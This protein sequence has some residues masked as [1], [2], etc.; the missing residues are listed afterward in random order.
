MSRQFP[1]RGSR[2]VSR[3]FALPV[4]A[5][6]ALIFGNAP[7]QSAGVTT[8]WYIG[9]LAYSQI[10]EKHPDLGRL[11]LSETVWYRR[12]TTFPDAAQTSLKD[13]KRKKESDGLSHNQV[14]DHGGFFTDY[15][16]AFEKKCG[17]GIE[18]LSAKETHCRRALAF[19]FGMVNHAIADG[20][21]HKTFIGHTTGR[22]CKLENKWGGHEYRHG[23]ADRDIDICLSSRLNG[24][25]GDIEATVKFSKAEFKRKSVALI[26]PAGEFLSG[27]DCYKCPNDAP[28]HF[29]LF[30]ADDKRVCQKRVTAPCSRI[31][32]PVLETAAAVLS[33]GASMKQALG[34][35]IA[36]DADKATR[37]FVSGLLQTAYGKEMSGKEIGGIDK[38]MGKFYTTA[39]KEPLAVLSHLGGAKS[40]TRHVEQCDWAFE[41]VMSHKAAGGIPD[42]AHAVA[43]AAGALWA[44]MKSGKPVEFERTGSFDYTIKV[45]GKAEYC[46][47]GC[48]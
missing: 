25:L 3:L 7:T 32:L 8:H 39:L 37:D 41:N 47:G 27:T 36:T 21:W 11:L 28:T 40:F 26:C 33:P 18:G 48:K 16:K 17:R 19:F 34:E 23:L 22:H 29:I 35:M 1:L 12:G 14:D 20:P 30:A 10:N 13:H 5:V 46:T 44:G 31:E 42:S 9:G 6:A 15:L 4:L 45:A 43:E 38:E 24:N 2:S